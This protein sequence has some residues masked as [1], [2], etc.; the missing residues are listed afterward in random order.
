MKLYQ[1]LG[2][3]YS[4]YV[5]EEFSKMGLIAGKDFEL[6]EARRGTPGREEVVRLG[7]KNQ[8]PFLVDGDT[9]MYESRDIVTYVR[10]KLAS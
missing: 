8:V 3:P 10:Q 2:C 5:R 4:A 9:Q 7:G 1:Y 6:V